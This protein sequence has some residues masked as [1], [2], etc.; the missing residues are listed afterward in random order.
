MQNVDLKDDVGIKVIKRLYKQKFKKYIYYHWIQ[1]SICRNYKVTTLKKK[2]YQLAPINRT[3]QFIPIVCT[4]TSNV[5]LK[6]D[7][8]SYF[9]ALITSFTKL[10]SYALET[11]P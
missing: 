10:E 2:I 5:N 6:W 8:F 1:Q 11:Y 4:N 9:C 7:E 3:L